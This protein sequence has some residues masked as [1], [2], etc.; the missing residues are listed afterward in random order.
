VSHQP[1]FF[2]RSQTSAPHPKRALD[3]PSTRTAAF[4][5]R[6]RLRICRTLLLA[7]PDLRRQENKTKTFSIIS[8]HLSHLSSLIYLSLSHQILFL[9][10]LKLFSVSLISSR[11]CSYHHSSHLINSLISSLIIL[12]SSISTP[13]TSAGV[14]RGVP[15]ARV[16]ALCVGF[17]SRAIPKSAR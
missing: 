6:T 1:Q 12:I 8:C 16:M 17:S 4:R 10:S 11:R 5:M 14:N 3:P 9:S 13:S 2:L 15:A 7:A